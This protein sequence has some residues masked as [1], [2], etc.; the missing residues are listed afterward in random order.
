VYIPVL[1]LG[2]VSNPGKSADGTMI[3]SVPGVVAA[4]TEVVVNAAAVPAKGPATALIVADKPA[5]PSRVSGI[6]DIAFVKV[7]GVGLVFNTATEAVV[8]ELK[9]IVTPVRVPCIVL[10]LGR[11]NTSVN[12]PIVCGTVNEKL[13]VAAVASELVAAASTVEVKIFRSNVM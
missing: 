11:V 2:G 3:V 6:E 13:C 7:S 4:G 1:P 10:K 12:A 5:G 8:E 9:V